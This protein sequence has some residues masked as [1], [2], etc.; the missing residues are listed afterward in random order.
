MQFSK[1]TPMSFLNEY[2]KKP[3]SYDLDDGSFYYQGNT[4]NPNTVYF[5]GKWFEA[6]LRGMFNMKVVY[7]K[8]KEI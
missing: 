7:A 2:N 3:R 6:V 8:C 5:N 1:S 4:A